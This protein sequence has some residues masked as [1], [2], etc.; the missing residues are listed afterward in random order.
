MPDA[1]NFKVREDFPL[2]SG[3]QKSSFEQIFLLN[4]LLGV[5]YCLLILLFAGNLN[6]ARQIGKLVEDVMRQVDFDCR[7]SHAHCCAWHVLVELTSLQIKCC[8]SFLLH[9]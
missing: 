3:S 6:D 8:G 1:E 7:S 5:C 2:D 9:L 4:D